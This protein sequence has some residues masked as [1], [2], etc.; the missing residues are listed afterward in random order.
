MEEEKKILHI[1]GLAF[2]N[3]VHCL[4][5]L[6]QVIE[7]LEKSPLF[8]NVKLISTDENKLYNQLATG[9]DIICDIDSSP[10]HQKGKGKD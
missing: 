6:A 10:L 7:G 9:F 3:D 5:A 4:T 1:G 8:S 2:G